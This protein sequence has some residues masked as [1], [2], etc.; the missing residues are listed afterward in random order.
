MRQLQEQAQ[1][2]RH[3]TRR[4]KRRLEQHEQAREI[5]KQVA[6]KTQQQVRFHLADTVTASMQAVFS[7]PYA[8]R[9]DFVERRGRTE[10]D[11]AFERGE[12]V[13]DPLSAAGGGTVDVASFALRV[14]AWAMQRPRS[15]ALLVLDEP[16]RY[17]SEDLLPR[18]GDMLRQVSAELGLQ[19]V[20]VTHADELAAA[21]DKVFEVRKRGVTSEVR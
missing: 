7:D 13:I 6:L 19:I 16:F 12:D 8:L 2:A 15:R 18:A 14:A 4:S 10:C 9:V 5:I 17:L 3:A 21:A 1:E 11:L 20:L